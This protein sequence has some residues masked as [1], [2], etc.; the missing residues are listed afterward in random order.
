M[1]RAIALLTAL[2]LTA[3]I[4]PAQDVDESA[5]FGDT[6]TVTQAP[7]NTGDSAT[8]P[9]IKNTSISGDLTAVGYNSFPRDDWRGS[10][11]TTMAVGDLYLD[12]RLLQGIKG[13]ASVEASYMASM[14]T[15]TFNLREMFVDMNVRGRVYLRAGKQVLQWGRCNLWNPVDLINV[16]RKQFVQRIG[17]REGVFGLKAHVPFGTAVNLYGFIDTRNAAAPDSLAGAAKAEFIIKGTEMAFSAWGKQNKMPVLGYDISSR[18]A[19]IDIAGEVALFRQDNEYRMGQ[20]GDSLFLLKGPKDWTPRIALNLSHSFDVNGVPDRLLVSVEGYYNGAGYDSHMFDDKK[21]YA[22]ANSRAP[23]PE[24]I[25]M[26]I[27]TPFGDPIDTTVTVQRSLPPQTKLEYFIMNGLY[28]PNEHSYYYAALFT[29]F[30]RFITS[31]MSLSFNAIG[32]LGERC[33]TLSGSLSY[34][35]LRNLSLSLTILGYA[36]PVEREYTL[37][38]RFSDKGMTLYDKGADVQFTAGISF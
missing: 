12:A 10:T 17:S 14:D 29:S 28:R 33:A 31:N 38:Y 37:G 2:L 32:N 34:T 22:Y 25:R 8:Q 18:V 13:Y 20:Q 21:T 6:A 1:M 36:G 16:E 4:L 9:P 5:L 23:Q 11:L 3:G 7:L 26:T 35:D 19:L 24:T 27:P 30:S 15:T